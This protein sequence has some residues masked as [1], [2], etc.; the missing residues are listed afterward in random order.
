MPAEPQRAAVRSGGGGTVEPLRPAVKRP[1]VKVKDTMLACRYEL[2]YRISEPKARALAEYVRAFIEPDRYARLRPRGE[3]PIVSLYFDSDGFQLARETLEGKKNRFKLRVRG[4]SDDP[5]SPCFFEVKRRVS[6]VILKSRARVQHGDVEPVLRTGRV[7]T[8]YKTDEN[9]LRQY[10]LYAQ[11]INAKPLVLI[12]YMREAYEGDS[13]NRVRITFD[14]QLCY[15]IMREPVV[16]LGGPGWQEARLDFVILEI[17]FTA[18]YPIWLSRMVRTFDLKQTA[19]SKYAS[20][21][22]LSC[23]S[24]FGAPQAYDMSL[25]QL[26]GYIDG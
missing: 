6:N 18:V 21:V 15:R 2:K 20:A 17:K 16:R 11:Y 8:G 14:R 24:R 22:R 4:Y 19:M 13:D 5:E 9:A 7:P 12:R 25:S 26:A 1:P 23:A 10:V 3:Y